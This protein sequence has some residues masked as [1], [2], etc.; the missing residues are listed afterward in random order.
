MI[1]LRSQL[2]GLAFVTVL[3]SQAAWS[4]PPGETKKTDLQEQK[5]V[6]TDIYGD[7]LPP[8]AIGRL[9]TIRLCHPNGCEAV[10]FSADEKTLVSV[11]GGSVWFWDV[12]TGKR[13]RKLES[14]E[15]RVKGLM[16][17]SPDRKLLAVNGRFAEAIIYDLDTGRRLRAL[18]DAGTF[19]YAIAFSPDGKLLATG[20]ED[21]MIRLWDVGSGKELRKYTWHGSKISA[22]A[23][24][25]GGK[26]LASVDRSLNG[27]VD[28]WDTQ[29]GERLWTY[30]HR[31]GTADSVAFSPDGKTLAVGGSKGL[32]LIN[33]SNGDSIRNEPIRAGRVAFSPDST[34]LAAGGPDDVLG[35]WESSTGKELHKLEGAKVAI[36]SLQFSPTGKYLACGSSQGPISL[37]EVA[38]GKAV[39]PE[40]RNDG[41]IYALAFSPDGK[42]LATKTHSAVQLWDCTT[43]KKIQRITCSGEVVLFTPDGKGILTDDH[44]RAKRRLLLWRLDAG[45]EVGKYHQVGGSLPNGVLPAFSPDGGLIAA[46]D[47]GGRSPSWMCQPVR[48]FAN[49][50]LRRAWL[51]LYTHAVFL[52]RGRSWQPGAVGPLS[53]CGTWQPADRSSKSKVL[54]IL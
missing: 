52:L 40:L 3:F 30:G 54:H 7:P 44:D 5:A 41:I 16:A 23:F 22:V 31:S 12:E 4:A 36:K 11:G 9:G 24:A 46:G 35:L 19:I 21:Q 37:W 42:T 10:V 48:Y 34:I 1:T 18:P 51:H 15:D 32:S 25:P 47:G 43:G 53:A 28:A 45:R 33:A 8:G 20:C 17:F 29:T 50:N 39:H 26:L 27:T 2:L 14:L 6:R 49:L 38:T 13:L